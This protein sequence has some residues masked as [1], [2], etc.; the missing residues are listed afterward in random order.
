M[1]GTQEWWDPGSQI[2][3]DAIND[4]YNQGLIL[5]VSAGNDGIDIANEFYTYCSYDNT[6]CVTTSNQY[7]TDS[8]GNFIDVSAP[9]G[10]CAAAPIEGVGVSSCVDGYG[11]DVDS[12]GDECYFRSFNGTSSSAPVVTGLVGLLLSHNPNLTNQDIYDIVTSTNINYSYGD[13]PGTIDFYEAL[14][15]L[16]EIPGCTDPD[17]NNYNP[18]AT[19]NDGSC[20]YS[21]GDMNQDGILNILDIVMWVDQFGEFEGDSEVLIV[22]YPEMDINNDGIVNILDLVVLL[23]MVME[24]EAEPS[25]IMKRIKQQISRL[26]SILSP[27]EKAELRKELN[28]SRATPQL[29]DDVNQKFEYNLKSGMIKE[30]LKRQK[31]G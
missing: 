10:F 22:E 16:Y 14:S 7:N 18:D 28:K 4:A 3:Q 19:Y 5:V 25:M 31:N 24:F 21:L 27:D 13:R 6:L 11:N 1:G 29:S 12:W 2:I 26:N 17:A 8:S 23:N 20:D 9:L 30:I 15:K